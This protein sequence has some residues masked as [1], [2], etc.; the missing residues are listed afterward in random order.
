MPLRL[1]C[2][3]ILIL[4]GACLPAA[5]L[6]RGI[7]AAQD[8]RPQQ[9]QTPPNA[10]SDGFLRLPGMPPVNLPSG[11]HIFGSDGKELFG[12]M[13]GIQNEPPSVGIPKP[14]PKQDALTREERAKAA[15][16]KALKEAIAPQPT[17]AVIRAQALDAL[18]KR[19][20]AAGD[21]E[22]ASGIVGAIERVWMRSDS[23]TADLLMARAMAAQQAGHLPLAL[24]LYDKVV[25][26]QPGWAEAWNKRATTRLLGDDLSGAVA[27][28]EQV[29]KLEP[30][31]FSA[32]V[33]MGFILEK[34]GFD[35]RALEAFRKALAVNPQQPEIRSV[36]DKLQT[37]VEGRDI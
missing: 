10:S 28:L 35:K 4:I 9:D 19:L 2:W 31:H 14:L 25:L 29:L 8:D 18:F 22:E 17:H 37:Q 20:A 33:A 13:Q 15:K 34:Q 3:P 27:D 16:A 5:A 7:I 23:D 12:P 24:T 1:L 32:L 21:P 30:R 36:V 6:D 11:V 26:L